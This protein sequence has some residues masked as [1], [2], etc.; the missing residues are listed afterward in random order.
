MQYLING[1]WN[2]M[3]S[4]W[5]AYKPLHGYAMEDNCP[6]VP[7]EYWADAAHSIATRRNRRYF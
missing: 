4:G 7:V 6:Y 1:C 2:A 3:R 5:I